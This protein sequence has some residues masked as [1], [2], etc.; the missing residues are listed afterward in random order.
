MHLIKLKYRQKVFILIIQWNSTILIW[1]LVVVKVA[2]CKFVSDIQKEDWPLIS[3]NWPPG[4]WNTTDFVIGR[5]GVRGTTGQNEKWQKHDLW[6]AILFLI[7]F[8]DI[9]MFWLDY[10]YQWLSMSWKC[11]GVTHCES[12]PCSLM[13]LLQQSRLLLSTV[14]V[15][16]TTIFPP[17]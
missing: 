2:V 14:L 17:F 10:C 7:L 9:Q 8:L 15:H 11:L 6:A 4:C 5:L 1:I 3:G 16:L 12:P 13:G